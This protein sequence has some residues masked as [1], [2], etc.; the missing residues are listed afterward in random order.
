LP[1]LSPDLSYAMGTTLTSRNRRLLPKIS[2]FYREDIFIS[3]EDSALGELGDGDC[4]VLR[5]KNI[6]PE[7]PTREE[8]VQ[9]CVEEVQAGGDNSLRLN[10]AF[11]DELRLSPGQE[12]ELIKLIDF[13]PIHSLT[14]E[15][16]PVHSFS[17]DEL[18]QLK[19]DRF[20]GRC[21]LVAP[22]GKAKKL[23]LRMGGG[24]FFN[25]RD[26]SPAAVSSLGQ[27]ALRIE[28]DT[29]INIHISGRRSE[30]DLVLILDVSKSMKLNDLVDEGGN[31]V[32]RIEAARRVIEKLLRWHS[33]Y[34]SP[35]SRFGLIIF[36]KSA[37]AAYP[38]GPAGLAEISGFAAE[39]LCREIPNLFKRVDISGSNVVEALRLAESLIS[40]PRDKNND[41]V[42]ILISDGAYWGWQNLSGTEYANKLNTGAD[43]GMMAYLNKFYE[44]SR[45]P[46]H[47]VAVGSEEQTRRFAPRHYQDDLT[48]P[49]GK[50]VN[51]PNPKVLEQISQLTNGRFCT[52]NELASLRDLFGEHPRAMTLNIPIVRTR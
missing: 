14:L 32:T 17:R 15:P 5:V 36:G 21:L 49:E 8:A 30:T 10:S 52:I 18:S 7:M 19:R 4:A 48:R 12:W 51:I 22:D 38:D 20:D 40:D 1:D 43:A 3:R 47:T 23:I 31:I 34:N 13:R 16:T 35:S 11:F 50:R 44:R 26:I 25:I 37:N 29:V 2:E 41:K 28:S 9:V 45:M 24:K 33:S 42:F 6:V 39:S 46:I 27:L